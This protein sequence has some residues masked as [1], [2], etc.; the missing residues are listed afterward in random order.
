M[1]CKRCPEGRRFAAGCTFCRW[2]G[3]ILPD[4][5][6]CRQER[7]KY[8]ERNYNFRHEGYDGPAVRE[9]GGWFAGGV[10][11]GLDAGDG[12][13]IPGMEE[14]RAEEWADS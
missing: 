3:M 7:G 2:Y 6:E 10:S 8:H 5:H 12:S 1:K 13:G 11:E 14:G 9:N 4:E